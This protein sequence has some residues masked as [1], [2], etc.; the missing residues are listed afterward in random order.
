MGYRLGQPNFSK[1]EIAPALWGRFDVDAYAT[2]VRTGRNCYVL[3]YGGLE[4]RPGTRFVAEVLDASKPLRLVPF[5][6]SI[7]QAYAL[8]MG[9]GYAR[10]AAKGGLVLNEEL[11]IAG[12][13]NEVQARLAALYHGYSVGNQIYLSGLDGGLGEELNGRIATVV[14]VVDADNIRID[15]D[16][17][18]MPVFSGSTGGITRTGAPDPDPTDPVVPDPVEPPTPPPTTGRD[19]YTLDGNEDIP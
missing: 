16:T 3:K 18:A 2:A 9:Q 11:H 10:V 13:T 4:K 6:F 1:G 5:Q 8:E 14:A 12:I 15:I 17:S 7:E 19:R